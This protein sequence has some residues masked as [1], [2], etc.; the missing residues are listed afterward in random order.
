MLASNINSLSNFLVLLDP[1]V[2]KAPRIR[3]SS[4]RLCL[5]E[6][7]IYS[8]GLKLVFILDVVKLFC[9]L[10][11]YLVSWLLDGLV[12]MC[13]LLPLIRYLFLIWMRR[14]RSGII[15]MLVANS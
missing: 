2:H 14:R 13:D 10:L 4:L 5:T 15:L 9:S 11:V 8:Y 3:R 7:R 1:G 6:G 12:V